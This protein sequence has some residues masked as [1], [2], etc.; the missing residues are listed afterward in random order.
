MQLARTRS[1][2]FIA[3][4]AC[5]AVLG[6]AVFLRHAVSP[7]PCPL[8]MIQ[9]GLM[10][11]C[12]VICLAAAIHKPGLLGWRLYSGMLLLI[13][14]SGAAIAARQVWL[15]ESPPENLASCLENL[16]YLLDTQPFTKVVYLILI[17]GAG[18]AE[19]TWT[20]FGISLPEWSLLAFSGI[21]LFALCYLLIEFRRPGSMDTGI[22]D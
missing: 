8:C 9:R 11:V 16:R 15:Q 7:A 19:I 3:F 22:T 18:C 12:A 10:L 6:G 2:F 4:L 20:L 14:L 5:A 17:G 21:S 13:S 1:L